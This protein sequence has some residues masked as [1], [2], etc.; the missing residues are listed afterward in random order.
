MQLIQTIAISILFLS[1]VWL[2]WNFARFHEIQFQTEPKSFLKNKKKYIPTNK[3][4]K[5]LSISKQKSFVH[6]L[7][8]P[9]GFDFAYHV[10]CNFLIIKQ[11][12]LHSLMA[13]SDFLNL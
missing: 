7:N 5:P 12:L 8:F 13:N 2:S 3:I 1:V 6:Y 9:E 4:F 11:P 10:R